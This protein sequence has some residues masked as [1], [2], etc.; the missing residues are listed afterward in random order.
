MSLHT[1]IYNYGSSEIIIYWEDEGI[2]YQEKI[3]SNDSLYIQP[4]INHGFSCSAKNGKL[5]I[6]RVSGSINLA[7][8]RELSY[9]SN[10]D[11]AF[12]EKKPW[13]N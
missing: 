4:F 3:Q 11:R 2:S 1:Y 7:T 12:N 6:V 8:Q 13:F 10:I 9:M 5:F